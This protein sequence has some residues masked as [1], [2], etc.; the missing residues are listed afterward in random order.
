MVVRLA[1]GAAS[2]QS[3][4]NLLKKFII[5]LGVFPSCTDPVSIYCENTG[6]IAN[7]REPRTHSTAKHIL[8]RFHVTRDYIKDGHIKICKIHMDLNAADPMT[9]PLLQGKL[10]QHRE[11]IGVR[12]LPDVI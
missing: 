9:K 10:D 8:R 3:S 4:P 11:T 6:A 7:A 5:E 12:H 1:G 2:S